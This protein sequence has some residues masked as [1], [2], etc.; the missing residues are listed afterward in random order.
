MTNN[1]D[2]IINKSDFQVLENSAICPICLGVIISPYQCTECENS[3]CQICIQTYIK[4]KPL[5]N[6]CPFRCKNPNFKPSRLLNN[7]LQKLKF[8]CSN[9]CKEEINYSDLQSHYE[10]CP[11]G[12]PKES[13]VKIIFHPHKISLNNIETNFHCSICD[14]DNFEKAYKCDE[15]NEFNICQKCMNNYDEINKSGKILDEIHKHYLYD[16]TFAKSFWKCN[17]CELEFNNTHTG[18]PNKRYRCNLCDFDICD[19]CII[20]KELLFKNYHEH[21]LFEAKNYP[22]NWICDICQKSYNE[23]IIDRYR[24]EICD[25]DICNNCKN[26]YCFL[27]VKLHEHLLYDSTLKETMWKCNICNILHLP[28]DIRRYR[29]DQCDFDVCKDC[30]SKNE[31]CLTF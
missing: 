8:K 15:C 30:L 13:F 2:L 22:S 12:K 24:C 29:C 1:P 26:R 25:F 4:G 7:L 27:N 6:Q 14:E 9:N 3:F 5:E 10:K 16:F 31:K 28:G 19:K 20:E 18:I 17:I 11:L 23:G 21:P